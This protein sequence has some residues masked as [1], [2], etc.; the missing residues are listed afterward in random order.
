MSGSY[1]F[2]DGVDSLDTG[3][4]YKIRY[5]A[6]NVIGDGPVCDELVV[7]LIDTPATPNAPVNIIASSSKTAIAIDWT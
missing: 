1:I 3:K 6:H 5:Y 7:A 4:I 2:N